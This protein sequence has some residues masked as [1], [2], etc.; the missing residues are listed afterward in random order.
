MSANQF[1]RDKN[2]DVIDQCA[3]KGVSQELTSAFEQYVH[4]SF[5]CQYFQRYSQIDAS[6]LVHRYR[7]NIEA[8]VS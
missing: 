1:G 7:D 3:I 5:A 4:N 6:R 2:G 8:V